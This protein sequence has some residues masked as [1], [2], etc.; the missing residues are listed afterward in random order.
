MSHGGAPVAE[1]AGVVAADY[2]RWLHRKERFTLREMKRYLG[3]MSLVEGALVLFLFARRMGS[4][5]R[6]AD[7]VIDVLRSLGGQLIAFRRDRAD[8]GLRLYVRRA[9]WLERVLLPAHME[10][11]SRPELRH[12][13]V[14]E[15]THRSGRH[16]RQRVVRARYPLRDSVAGEGG[17]A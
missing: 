3:N 1:S 14:A 4:G 9:G 11:L 13:V 8:G 2:L 16:A 5:A 6:A 12:L 17:A 10:Q 7:A 15:L